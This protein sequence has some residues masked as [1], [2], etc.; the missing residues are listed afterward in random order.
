MSEKIDIPASSVFANFNNDSAYKIVDGNSRTKWVGGQ[1]PG[2]ADIKLDGIYR[3][4]KIVLDCPKNDICIFSVFASRDFVNFSEIVSQSCETSRDGHYELS[5]SV[6]A[7]ALRFLLKY[8]SA[9]SYAVLK[10][11]EI[12]GYPTGER[13][14]KAVVDFPESFEQSRYNTPVDEGETKEA[15]YGIVERA[16]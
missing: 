9:S 11:I 1:F 2:Y 10:N 5:C 13:A 3:I 16:E 15:L 14:E 6:S 12:F 7:C 8:E 4:D